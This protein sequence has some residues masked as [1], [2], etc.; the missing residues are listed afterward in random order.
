MAIISV[1]LLAAHRLASG[2]A[3]ARPTTAPEGA[4]QVGASA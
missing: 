3:A 4:V 1:A 2:R